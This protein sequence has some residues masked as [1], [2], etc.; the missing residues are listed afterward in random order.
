MTSILR[1][2]KNAGFQTQVN[3][4]KEQ[5]QMNDKNN[6]SL[7]SSSNAYPQLGSNPV[8]AD[9]EFSLKYEDVRRYVSSRLEIS[10]V[11]GPLWFNCRIDKR[12]SRVI[13]AY[14]GNIVERKVIPNKEINGNE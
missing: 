14:P 3:S 10:G 7:L 4:L 1:E 5:L 11:L 8:V 6:G 13:A 9:L 2:V 12:T